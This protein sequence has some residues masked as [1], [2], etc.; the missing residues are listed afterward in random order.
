MDQTQIKL[1]IQGGQ[2]MSECVHE[3]NNEK[4]CSKCDLTL[5][6]L[7]AQ[8]VSIKRDALNMTYND[9]NDEINR[10]LLKID[11][12]PVVSEMIKQC[13]SLLNIIARLKNK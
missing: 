8:V 13:D 1:Q 10:L 7:S 2:I 3:F 11:V 9:F 4:Q 6:E 12:E 5:V